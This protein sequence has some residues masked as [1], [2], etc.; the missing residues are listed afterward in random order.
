MMYAFAAAMKRHLEPCLL[1][2]KPRQH[3]RIV[4]EADSKMADRARL[5]ICTLIV[6]TN[7]FKQITLGKNGV[8]AQRRCR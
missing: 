5:N 8:Q 3:T 7:L 4:S 1:K 2:P 6:E